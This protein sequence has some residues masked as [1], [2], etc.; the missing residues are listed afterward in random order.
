MRFVQFL[1]GD[2]IVGFFELCIS[3][4]IN[5][6]LIFLSVLRVL[7]CIRCEFLR[8]FFINS[9]GQ[10]TKRNSRLGLCNLTVFYHFSITIN[11]ISVLIIYF[12]VFLFLI[13]AEISFPWVRM[14]PYANRIG[15]NSLTVEWFICPSLFSILFHQVNETCTHKLILTLPLTFVGCLPLRC[16]DVSLCI[17]TTSNGT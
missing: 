14:R 8:I 17:L 15:Y 1:R 4:R 6:W 7:R 12:K 10:R 2:L 9:F 5:F 11:R 16:D 13:Y 3:M